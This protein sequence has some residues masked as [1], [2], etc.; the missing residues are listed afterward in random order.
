MMVWL[1]KEANNT[2]QATGKKDSTSF[3][4]MTGATIYEGVS[5]FI[6]RGSYRRDWNLY[7]KAA[8]TRGN[9]GCVVPY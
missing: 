2:L 7:I 1:V 5:L 6:Y 8:V 3:K 4:D 9:I